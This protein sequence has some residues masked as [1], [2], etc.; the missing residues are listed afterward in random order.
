[1]DATMVKWCAQLE[2][3]C[4]LA[5]DHDIDLYLEA[6]ENLRDSD[7]PEVLHCMLRCFRDTDAGE[8]QYELVEACEAFADEVYVKAFIEEGEALARN[9]PHWFELMFQSILNTESCAEIALETVGELDRALSRFWIEY[10]DNLAKKE[11]QYATMRDRM[12]SLVS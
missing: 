11:P 1:M 2:K 3:A 4:G 9:S 5:S 7:D 10:T 8:V 12:A 6:I